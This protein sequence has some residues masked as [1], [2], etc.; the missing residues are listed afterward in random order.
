MLTFISQICILLQPLE[1]PNRI[2]VEV[3]ID[4]LHP[5]CNKKRLEVDEGKASLREWKL[6]NKI[7]QGGFLC[8]S[9]HDGLRLGGIN[10]R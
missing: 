1:S 7:H 3:Q 4:G 8:I 2:F 5:R 10:L 6:V 9:V